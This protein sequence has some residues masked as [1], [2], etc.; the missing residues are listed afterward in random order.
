MSGK[1]NRGII[2]KS[3]FGTKLSI[4][5]MPEIDDSTG[6]VIGTYGIYIPKKHMLEKAFE[7]FAPIMIEAQLPGTSDLYK[8][9]KGLNQVFW[10]RVWQ[11]LAAMQ[12]YLV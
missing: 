11:K 12:T 6:V 3:I 4:W 8:K 7:V 5:A 10:S 1:E 2:D 9:R